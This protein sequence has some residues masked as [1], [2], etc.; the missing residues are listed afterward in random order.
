MNQFYFTVYHDAGSY[1]VIFCECEAETIPF[2]LVAG[3]CSDIISVVCIWASGRRTA[4]VDNLE[5]TL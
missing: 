2:H 5:I 1:E 3:A 4:W